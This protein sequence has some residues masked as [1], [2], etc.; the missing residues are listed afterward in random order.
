MAEFYKISSKNDKMTKMMKMKKMTRY[1]KNSAWNDFYVLPSHSQLKKQK[2]FTVKQ[3]KKHKNQSCLLF[4]TGISEECL[5]L[6]FWQI[7]WQIIVNVKSTQ[8]PI[9]LLDGFWYNRP[10]N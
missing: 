5:N 9:C 10:D 7:F 2:N 1:D 6:I 4:L 8:K 3:E